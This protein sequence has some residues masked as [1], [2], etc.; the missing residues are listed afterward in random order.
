MAYVV[1][2][3]NAK[4]MLI[5]V[6]FVDT[7]SDVNLYRSIGA[8]K[9]ADAI[10]KGLV[11]QTTTVNTS[12]PQVKPQPVNNTS[13]VSGWVSRLQNELNNQGFRDCNGNRLVV[14]NISGEKTLS[15][16]PTIKR[17]AKGNI[18][19][20]ILEKLNSLGFNCGTVDGDF[21][22]NTYNAVVNFQRSKGLSADGIIGKNTWRKLL[23]L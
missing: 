16:C 23:G 12:Q 6:C 20:L 22:G 3:T 17:G 2:H 8:E 11:G 7:Q 5:E 13:N 1:N 9:I 14:D 19:R 10:V 4:A 21:G 18:T 15:A